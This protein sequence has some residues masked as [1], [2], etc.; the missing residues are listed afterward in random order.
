M[1]L[2]C[3]S[4]WINSTIKKTSPRLT[5]SGTLITTMGKS[6]MLLRRESPSGGEIF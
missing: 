6:P 4:T 5:S 1:K 3:L 2:S